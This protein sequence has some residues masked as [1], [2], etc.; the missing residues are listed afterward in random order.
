[1]PNN[2]YRRVA[3]LRTPEER[4]RYVLNQMSDILGEKVNTVEEAQNVVD[5]LF[6]EIVNKVK[7]VFR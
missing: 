2:R 3:R 7:E 5:S 4:E 6:A 1:M